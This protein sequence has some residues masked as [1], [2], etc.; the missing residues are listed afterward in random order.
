MKI[1]EKQLR[2]IIKESIEQVLKE[3]KTKSPGKVFNVDGVD[4]EAVH[5]IKGGGTIHP[6]YKFKDNSKHNAEKLKHCGRKHKD[7]YRYAQDYES[8]PHNLHKH[9]TT[10][11]SNLNNSL[12]Q[13]EIYPVGREHMT[14]HDDANS[15]IKGQFFSY[16]YLTGRLEKLVGYDLCHT[17]VIPNECG[18]YNVK[19]L[20]NDEWIKANM[21]YWVY[22][23]G[24]GQQREGYIVDINDEELNYYMKKWYDKHVQEREQHVNNCVVIKENVSLKNIIIYPHYNGPMN[25]KWENNTIRFKNVY[26]H[27]ELDDFIG[28]DLCR[29]NTIPNEKGIYSVKVFTENKLIPARLYFWYSEGKQCGYVVSIRDT[30]GNQEAL[31]L[32]ENNEDVY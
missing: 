13:I 18:I 12:E 3:R 6:G 20:I 27:G 28:C 5:K 19:V 23:R 16:V 32:F 29:T 15:P 25:P 17:N 8:T 14:D 2:H 11:S 10:E 31:E 30:K 21:Y 24:G 4:Y 9:L 22:K 1:T 7:G 26:I